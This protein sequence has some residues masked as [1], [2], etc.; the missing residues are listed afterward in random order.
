LKVSANVKI[1]MQCF[2]NLEGGQMPSSG[3]APAGD[4]CIGEPLVQGFPTFSSQVP[5][6]IKQSTW[7]PSTLSVE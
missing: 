3:C 5:L 1:A 7:T 6:V 2:E 4:M